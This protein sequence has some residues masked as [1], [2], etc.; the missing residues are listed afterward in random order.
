MGEKNTKNKIKKKQKRTKK[1]NKKQ[2]RL[3]L[4]WDSGKKKTQTKKKYERVRMMT[5]L[6]I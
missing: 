2:I 5:A 1:E 4:E 3:S 6:A